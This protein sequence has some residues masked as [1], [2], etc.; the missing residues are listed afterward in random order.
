VEGL[1]LEVV[2]S[3]FYIAPPLFGKKIWWSGIRHIILRAE[4][5]NVF[6]LLNIE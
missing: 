4:G 3:P 5:G 2:S 1:L 6:I